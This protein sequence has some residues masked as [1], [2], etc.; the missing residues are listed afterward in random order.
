MVS[1]GVGVE[2]G[3]SGDNVADVRV[4]CYLGIQ[5]FAEGGAIIE[6][7]FVFECSMGDGVIEKRRSSIL[8]NDLHE[9]R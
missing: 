5:S 6:S 4:D 9:V 3:E 2:T 8:F 1:G 7:E